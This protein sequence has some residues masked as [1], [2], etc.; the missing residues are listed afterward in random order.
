MRDALAETVDDGYRLVLR[1]GGG[2]GAH[3][4]RLGALLVHSGRLG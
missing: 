1:L 4:Q 3:L 2:Q